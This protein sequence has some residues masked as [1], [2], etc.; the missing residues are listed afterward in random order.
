MISLTCGIWK[1]QTHTESGTVVA[2]GW[3]ERNGEVLVKRDLMHNMVIIVNNAV[4]YTQKSL[5]VN[6]KCSQHKKEMVIM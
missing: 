3:D 4:L 6:I 2:M 1:S 5:R